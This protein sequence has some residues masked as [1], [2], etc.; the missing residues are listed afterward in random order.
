MEEAYIEFGDVI[1]TGIAFTFDIN[2]EYGWYAQ[3]ISGEQIDISEYYD[4]TE[5]CFI[6][7]FSDLG[8][9]GMPV[10]YPVPSE[11]FEFDIDLYEQI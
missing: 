1:N 10:N 5:G 9:G 2:S 7:Y 4:E 11:S 3:D 8:Y 6:I